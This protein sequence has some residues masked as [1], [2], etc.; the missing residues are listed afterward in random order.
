MTVVYP[1]LGFLVATLSSISRSSARRYLYASGLA[2]L[3][4][5][6]AFPFSSAVGYLSREA[7]Y[8][9]PAGLLPSWALLGLIALAGLLALLPLGP[10]FHG[11]LGAAGGALVLAVSYAWLS[12][13]VFLAAARPLNGLTEAAIA[14]FAG[15]LL[16][17][18]LKGRSFWLA[19]LLG[20]AMAAGGFALL[21]GPVGHT[22]FPRL[23]GYY[24]LIV[25]LAPEETEKLISEYNSSLAKT[26][27]LRKEIGLK[28]LQP[29]SGLADLA[30]GVPKDLAAK[31]VRLV[32]PATLRYGTTAVL[33]L[34]GLL[35]ASGLFLL[36][37]PELAEEGDLASGLTAAAVFLVLVPSFYATEF[38]LAKLVKG[39]PFFVNFLDRSWP[40][41]LADPAHNIFPL[42]EV[43]SQMAL[44]VEIALVGTFLAML[45][46]V[47]TSFLAARN[48]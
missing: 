42:Q 32:R 11:L 8:P 16:F 35:L 24:K 34:G 1:L 17:L 13:P 3:V 41:N 45:L 26:N 18:L 9:T 46:A 25:P 15:G 29:I 37:K 44:T 20:L 2:L 14:L 4:A 10:R 22:Y 40:P 27:E 19:L 12:R 23:N 31:G 30:G 5:F 33:F 39:W 36:R 48:L 38:S 21:S 47:P 43:A 28:P 6:F 7:I